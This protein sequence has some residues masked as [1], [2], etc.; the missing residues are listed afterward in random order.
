MA[1]IK[2]AEISA[3]IKNQLMGSKVGPSLDEVGTCFNANGMYFCNLF[4]N[5]H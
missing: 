4:S 2:P 5:S 1:N 3:I